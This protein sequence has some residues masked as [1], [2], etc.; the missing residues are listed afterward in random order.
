MST[1]SVSDLRTKLRVK[2]VNFEAKFQ[3]TLKSADK[4]CTVFENGEPGTKY[5]INEYVD[6]LTKE[7]IRIA[8]DIM[9]KQIKE[10]PQMRELYKQLDDVA[11][12]YTKAWNQMK[13]PEYRNNPKHRQNVD[14]VIQKCD[15]AYGRVASEIRKVLIPLVTDRLAGRK[16]EVKIKLTGLQKS[17]KEQ[18]KTSEG[19][20]KTEIKK[21][22]PDEWNEMEMVPVLSS[23]E[24]SKYTIELGV[25]ERRAE[26]ALSRIDSRLKDIELNYFPDLVRKNAEKAVIMATDY[27]FPRGSKTTSDA[28]IVKAITYNPELN[29]LIKMLEEHKKLK[30]KKPTSG[31]GSKPTPL[32]P[33]KPKK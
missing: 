10:N 31:T 25:L 7:G 32:I 18:T 11:I 6:G 12:S 22:V 3:S 5:K 13:D 19:L 14:M 1:P 15:A 27:R 28:E 4:Y 23:P 21:T 16:S 24:Q 17:L 30:T 8:L 9:D 29:E 33:K 20:R 2:L 26:N